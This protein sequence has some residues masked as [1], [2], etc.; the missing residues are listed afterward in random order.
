MKFKKN[1]KILITAGFAISLILIF[2]A[3]V[4]L[5]AAEGTPGYELPNPL[6]AQT[7]ED[8]VNGI[9]TWLYTITIPLSAIIILYAAFLF[10]TSGGDEEKIKK[11]K[12]ALTWA[13][14][15]VGIIVIGTGFI[16]LI[17]DLL[18]VKQQTTFDLWKEVVMR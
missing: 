9:A 1:T 2:S 17:K 13:L 11:A 4:I 16:V 12:R 15:G 18:G 7:F 8:L 5:L 10:M 6:Q 3:P 14:V